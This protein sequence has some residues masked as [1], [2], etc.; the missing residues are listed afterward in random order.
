MSVGGSRFA[1]AVKQAQEADAADKA[2]KANLAEKEAAAHEKRSSV[3]QDKTRESEKRSSTT[4]TMEDGGGRRSLERSDSISGLT[5]NIGNGGAK[6]GMARAAV[7][8][9]LRFKRAIQLA[10][11]GRGGSRRISAE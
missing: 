4:K 7:I 1:K 2:N 9:S 8:S 11:S 10:G 5:C 3:V 6:W